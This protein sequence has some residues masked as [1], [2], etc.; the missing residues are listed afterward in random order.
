MSYEEEDTWPAVRH[1][2]PA[3]YYIY[4]YIILYIYIIYIYIYEN[5]SDLHPGPHQAQ[6]SLGFRI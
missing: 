1:H 3:S 5:K 4:I 6:P 2:P